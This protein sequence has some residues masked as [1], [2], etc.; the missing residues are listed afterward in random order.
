V[1][2]AWISA[3]PRDRCAESYAACLRVCN[4]EGCQSSCEQGKQACATTGQVC[5]PSGW[6]HPRRRPRG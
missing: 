1:L 3:P 4:G 5:L 2:V 6:C